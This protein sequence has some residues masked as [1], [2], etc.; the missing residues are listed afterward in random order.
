[1]PQAEIRVF[2]DQDGTCPLQEWLD[3]LRRRQPKAYAKCLARILDL[4][5]EGNELRRPLADYLR[6]GIR[7][8]RIRSG[9][10]NYRILYAF[11]GKQIALL[12]HG[13][14]KQ[15]EIPDAD[16]ELAMECLELARRN[17]VQFTSE[18]E[19]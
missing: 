12:T 11:V 1:M 8:L 14:T 10:T 5:R 17:P 16:I 15:A 4:A 19:V 2:R 7:E 3:G 9:R 18:F 6:D 13:L